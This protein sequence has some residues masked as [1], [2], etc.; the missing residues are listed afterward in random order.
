[1]TPL[2]CHHQMSTSLD[3][4]NGGKFDGKVCRTSGT[5][6]EATAPKFS[7]DDVPFLDDT[8][9]Y[10]FLKGVTLPLIINKE[11]AQ[12]EKATF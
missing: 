11:K 12:E 10:R 1:M 9:M 4:K 2:G 5:G 7:I 6:G 3:V 8:N